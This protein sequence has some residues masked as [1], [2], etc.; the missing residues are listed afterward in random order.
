MTPGTTAHESQ[1]EQHYETENLYAAIE[2]GVE[3]LGRDPSAMTV[4]DLAPVD[5]FHT[6]G[7]EATVEL[8]HLAGLRA[9]DVVLDVGCGLGGTARH[10]ADTVGCTVH[11]I[12][13]TPEYIA[14][15]ERLNRAVGLDDRVSLTCGSA[16]SLPYDDASFDVVWTEHVQMN[17]PDKAQFYRE[18]ARVLKPGG[19]FLFHDVI[20]GSGDALTF[21]VPWA[22][23]AEISALAAEPDLREA[24]GACD[25][26]VTLWFDKTEPSIDFF[27]AAL[28]R[29]AENG[30]P[31]LGLHL[32]MGSSAR[33][34]LENHIANMAAG[35]TRVCMGMARR[36]G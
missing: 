24:M 28:D 2:R 5:E 23:V 10:L 30:P 14:V 34:K 33:T 21:P 25:L 35:R 31:P 12:D 16:L 4:D 17:I 29:I 9:T 18:I 26:D 1:V 15:G 8:A 13:L 20:E 6:R 19:R 11:G 32:L 36:V 7:R 3:A 27:R 22:S